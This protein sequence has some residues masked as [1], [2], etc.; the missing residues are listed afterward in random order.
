MYVGVYVWL[1]MYA[2]QC[3]NVCMCVCMSI[4]Q[5]GS[6]QWSW[7]PRGRPGACPKRRCRAGLD[8]FPCS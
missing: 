3:M 2:S 6:A 5:P 8:L 1:S 4:C 7:T